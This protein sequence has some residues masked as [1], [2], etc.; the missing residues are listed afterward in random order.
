MADISGIP[1]KP[2]EKEDWSVTRRWGGGLSPAYSAGGGGGTSYSE[3]TTTPSMERPEMGESPTYT[4]PKM[5]QKRLGELSRIAM[6]APMARH[7]MGLREALRKAGYSD[8]PNVKAMMT[9]RAL[10]GYGQGISD[11]RAGAH[12]E[13]MAEYMPEF[14]AASNKASLEF[15]AEVSKQRTDFL[16]DMQEYMGTMTERTTEGT[17]DEG[18]RQGG[19][20]DWY[21][22]LRGF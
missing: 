7:R 13:A 20:S 11:I 16:A 8:N 17:G 2:T 5:D 21:K 18:T 15:Q 12:K 4:A 1:R 3:R 14:Q 22:R 19:S 10:A 6:G 9:G